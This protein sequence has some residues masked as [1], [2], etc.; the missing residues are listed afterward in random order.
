M[1]WRGPLALATLAALA[2]LTWWLLQIATPLAAAPGAPRH[3]PDYYFS[4]PRIVRFDAA[5]RI[6]LDVTAERAVHYADDDSVALEALSVAY[7]APEGD[8]WRMTAERG[9]A[10]AS[11]EVITLDGAV[12][13]A[14]AQTDGGTGLELRTERVTLDTRTRVL[15]APGAVELVDAGTHVT[16]LGLVADLANDRIRLGRR[17]RGTYAQR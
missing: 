13:V 7:R 3:L 12:A 15:E 5:G 11:G 10:P 1:D 16:A 2:A 8:A 9:T 4:G 17:V 14:R 6:E